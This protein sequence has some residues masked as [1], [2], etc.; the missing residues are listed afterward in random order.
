MRSDF[1]LEG[2]G[3]CVLEILA[4]VVIRLLGAGCDCKSRRVFVVGLILNALH[5]FLYLFCICFVF[6]LGGNGGE[7]GATCSSRS[8]RRTCL[9]AVVGVAHGECGDDDASCT[10]LCTLSLRLCFAINCEISFV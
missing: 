5:L 4:G 8:R 9:M 6:V 10:H 3:G 7:G 1:N 2:V